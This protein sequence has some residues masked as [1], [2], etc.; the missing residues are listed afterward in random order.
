MIKSRRKISEAR[1]LEILNKESGVII[2]GKTIIVKNG[3]SGLT[4]CAA[5]DF[6]KNHCGYMGLMHHK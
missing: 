4:K 5:Y 3:F 1:A 2:K 6:L